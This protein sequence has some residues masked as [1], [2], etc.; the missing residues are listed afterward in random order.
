MTDTPQIDAD[1]DSSRAAKPRA[2]SV[3]AAT[4]ND[5]EQQSRSPATESSAPK[6]TG[7]APGTAS[8]M[9][10]KE[11][12]AGEPKSGVA[13]GNSGGLFEPGQGIDRER[14]IYRRVDPVV[15]RQRSQRPNERVDC[16]NLVRER[17]EEILARDE[18][19]AV[20]I[21]GVRADAALPIAALP[22]PL[23]GRL[24]VRNDQGSWGALN[25]SSFDDILRFLNDAVLSDASREYPADSIFLDWI[26]Y[27]EKTGDL[28]R[29][30]EGARDERMDEFKA[31]LR[32]RR[33]RLLLVLA[34]D[35]FID[36]TAVLNLNPGIR[37]LPWT[38]LWLA[39]L[40]NAQQALDL[41]TL[42][43]SIGK[44]LQQAGHWADSG[45]DRREKVLS[46]ELQ[47]LTRDN[48]CSELTS[49]LAAIS[50]VMALAAA[51]KSEVN[52]AGVRQ[53]LSRSL[54]ASK[55]GESVDPIA[56]VMLAVAAFAGGPRV[57]EYLAVCRKL[58]PGGPAETQRLPP[59]YQETILRDAV[60]A[61]RM[62]RE[63][64]TPPG[65]EV[66]F[67]AEHDLTL[68]G[69]AIR[70]VEGQAI[71]IG[72]KWKAIDLKR[73]VTR[74]YP[75][76]IY[77]LIQRIIDR[78][79]LLTLAEGEAILLVRVIC[80]IRDACDDGF[81][82][83]A[84]A[85]ALIGAQHG[86]NDLGTPLDIVA[87]LFPGR[88]P[89]KVLELL[90]NIRRHRQ[91]AR[92][93][94]AIGQPDQELRQNLHALEELDPEVTP[95]NFHDRVEWLAGTLREKSVR[96]L[97]H[98]L[99]R[100]RASSSADSERKRPMIA[101][102][103]GHL[104]TMLATET[105]L[106]MLTYMLATSSE[107][108]AREIGDLLRREIAR[109]NSAE[110]GE[111]VAT[112][113]GRLSA[114]LAWPKAPHKNWL[115][116][117]DPVRAGKGAD[118]R[119]RAMAVHVWD[120]AINDDVR[121]RI[122]PYQQMTHLRLVCR[123]FARPVGIVDPEPEG[124]ALARSTGVD[125]P[126]I[127]RVATGFFAQDATDWLSALAVLEAILNRPLLQRNIEN[128]IA[129]IVWVIMTGGAEAECTVLQAHVVRLM[130]DLLSA[131][132]SVLKLG[133][134]SDYQAAANRVLRAHV[135]PSDR[136]SRRWLTLYGLFW[137]AM[138]AHW[139]FTAFG[140]Q[141]FQ[142][143]SED[144]RCFRMLLDRIIAAAPRK[145]ASY[146]DGFGALAAAADKCAIRASGLRAPQSAELYRLKADRLR[147]LQAFFDQHVSRE[148]TAMATAE[149]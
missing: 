102:M 108:D 44:D 111:I 23:P 140:L 1:D 86:L 56:Q 104:Q 118:D 70:L 94:D 107:I 4:T 72:S 59:V 114:A 6:P 80:A 125:E 71:Q 42:H 110:L 138:L 88:N 24:F 54:G 22:S 19:E 20:V 121:W 100:M 69:L 68:S 143:G 95:E 47:K 67:D 97:T 55:P 40:A 132:T 145:S 113:D 81:N 18:A 33:F 87:T 51:E 115:I 149:D 128:R 29:L 91:L 103:L 39:E 76:L 13:T 48:A 144:D 127:A 148:L 75:G 134:Q 43:A 26:P 12:G 136:F 109:A 63:R 119:I 77:G 124:K 123:L 64:A 30:I 61:E 83:Q 5:A 126:L 131:L 85:A 17:L 146:R 139:R 120:T 60:D 28:A 14:L 73:E 38:D 25:R 106:S 46:F 84:L 133:P 50:T 82:D 122:K 74:G 130:G 135:T 66:V 129:D 53:D 3:T 34:I 89:E 90:E 78:R 57:D 98:H 99:L 58:L 15:E 32:E 116:A 117:F 37:L 9:P 65:W 7:T 93:L 36:T 137:P 141:P 27:S 142:P 35:R 10:G 41:N 96:R 147:G 31:R 49:A 112:I 45:D 11:P 92:S 62:N 8:K 101:S 79:L 2:D 105:Y 21:L 52:F 16:F